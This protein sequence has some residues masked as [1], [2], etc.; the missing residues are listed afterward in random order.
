ML[1]I[2]K[3]LFIS[4]FDRLFSTGFMFSVISG[5]LNLFHHRISDPWIKMIYDNAF[6]S[7][8]SYKQ[9]CYVSESSERYP[10]LFIYLLIR[11]FIS[12][13]TCKCLQSVWSYFIQM[14]NQ[15]WQSNLAQDL[16]RVRKSSP[17]GP[18]AFKT[19][20][21]NT[22]NTPQYD[23]AVFVRLKAHIKVEVLRRL[24]LIINHEVC[25]FHL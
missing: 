19:S 12:A 18:K 7:I 1:D 23:P 4:L 13:F 10:G 16:I 17:N 3:T 21:S 20:S 5:L 2:W 25:V 8:Q 24:W 15:I 9:N 6:S 14:G 22:L 11:S